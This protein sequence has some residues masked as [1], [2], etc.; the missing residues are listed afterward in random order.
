VKPEDVAKL[1]SAPGPKT[2]AVRVV[3][4]P[5]AA[6]K[7]AMPA[8]PAAPAK[9]APPKPAP[10][11]DA[12]PAMAPAAAAAIPPRPAG[13]E[14]IDMAVPDDDEDDLERMSFESDEF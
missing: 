12:L 4:K 7:P 14:G 8:K 11:S 2:V 3:A 10:M 9:P 1:M 13:S 5:A 6:A